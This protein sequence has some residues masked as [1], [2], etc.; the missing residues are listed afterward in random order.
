MRIE[1]EGVNNA[2]VQKT[3]KLKL[4][5]DIRKNTLVLL[6]VQRK[7]NKLI[8]YIQKEIIAIKSYIL[9]IINTF[10]KKH[11]ICKIH[12]QFVTKLK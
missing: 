12:F 3:D 2:G 11:F 7:R 9:T 4:K 8:I 5:T 1:K 10:K 6:I